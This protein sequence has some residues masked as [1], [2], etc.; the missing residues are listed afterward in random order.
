VG[1]NVQAR[2]QSTGDGAWEDDAI[3]QHRRRMAEARDSLETGVLVL[4]R[5]E[6]PHAE[7]AG[8]GE[9]AGRTAGRWGRPVGRDRQSDGC[10]RLLPVDRRLPSP[11]R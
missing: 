7:H 8:G 6:F 10:P 4:D 3:R 2:Q 5:P 1:G 9:W 11:E